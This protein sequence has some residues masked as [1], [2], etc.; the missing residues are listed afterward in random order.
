MF[1][2]SKP[3]TSSSLLWNMSGLFLFIY[4]RFN[5]TRHLLQYRLHIGEV[6]GIRNRGRRMVGTDRSTRLW[7]PLTIG[8]L[9]LFEAKI[10]FL[11]FVPIWQ[12]FDIAFHIQ[13]ASTNRCTCHGAVNWYYRLVYRSVPLLNGSFPASFSFF[14]SFSYSW[15]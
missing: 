9:T 1:C 3:P 6:L 15:Q 13:F 8:T 4:T 10:R 12:F 5:K 14:S 11:V 7:R 2:I